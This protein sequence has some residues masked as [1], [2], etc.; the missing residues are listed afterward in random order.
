MSVSERG[1]AYDDKSLAIDWKL[2]P[3]DIKVSAK[4]A[5]QVLLKNADLF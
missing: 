4:D 5:K 3:K 1:I 2:N